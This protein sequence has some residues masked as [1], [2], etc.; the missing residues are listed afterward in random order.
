[1]EIENEEE[2]LE[3][4]YE[5]ENY[6]TFN[7]N[8][9]YNIDNS[10]ISYI[11]QIKNLLEFIITQ[12][13]INKQFKISLFKIRGFDPIS[14]FN[15]IDTISSGFINIKD[16]KEYLSRYNIK[17]ESEF[18]HLFIR[19]FNKEGKD[20]HLWQKDFVTFLNFDINKNEIKLGEL[21]FDKD[22]INKIFLDLIKSEFEFIKG[23]KKLINEIIQIKEF[24]SYEA[25]NIISKNKNYIDCENLKIFLED[26]FQINEIKELIYRFDLN[27]NKRINYEEFQDFFFPFQSHLQFDEEEEKKESENFIEDKYYTNLNSDEN[28][29]FLSQKIE[30]KNIQKNETNEIK[31]N[32]EENNGFNNEEQK[33]YDIDNFKIKYDENLLNELNENQDLEDENNDESYNNIKLNNNDYKIK[34]NEKI[35][36]INIHQQNFPLIKEN[37]NKDKLSVYSI[38]DFNIKYDQNNILSKSEMILQNNNF[39]INK[40]NNDIINEF[41][42]EN[43]KDVSRYFIDYVHSLI[44]FEN[45]SENLKESISLCN[46]ISISD[47]FQIFNKDKDGYISKNNFM[48]I[49]QNKFYIYPTEQQIKLLYDRYDLNN[50]GILNFEEF[51]KMLSP[52]KEEYLSLNKQETKKCINLNNISFDTKKLVIEFF[53]RIIEN[54]SLIYD[55]KIKLINEKKFNFVFL[56]GIM[57]K[58]SQDGKTLNKNEFN[59][60]LENFQCF[61]TKFELDIIFYKFSM[62]NNEIR[63]DSLYKEIITY[64]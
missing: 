53:K 1:M 7:P 56:W 51:T 11:P 12:N 44:L 39:N 45:L 24:S 19:Q 36:D 42:T 10:N 18:L 4:E 35:N 59:T 29:H 15:E 37:E 52:M 28:I 61:S 38:N 34:T 22:E 50:D 31:S 6:L 43:D 27:N 63:Y 9:I 48:K 55:M 33:D 58:F 49:C 8:D 5:K 57:M 2:K 23:Q 14:I 20:N 64:N 25:F 40:N 16:L 13:N 46:D 21:N 32:N 41:L 26:K 30:D 3:E 62:G 17:I 54:E 47:L 60:F